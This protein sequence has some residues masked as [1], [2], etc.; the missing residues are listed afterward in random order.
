MTVNS[1]EDVDGYNKAVVRF[2]WDKIAFLIVEDVDINYQILETVLKKTNSRVIWA[3]NGKEGVDSFRLEKNI[4][5][6]LMDLQMPVMDGFEA[7]K[8]IRSINPKVTIIAYTAY[9]YEGVSE[10][11]ILAGANECL[12]K[13]FNSKKLLNTIRKYLFKS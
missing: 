1:N 10:K 9:A 12:I 11:I 6:I 5:I 3:Q 13:P 7:T 2:E 8:I 4:D